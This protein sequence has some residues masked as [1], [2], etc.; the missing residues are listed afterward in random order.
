MSRVLDLCLACEPAHFFGQE[1]E[2]KEGKKRERGVGG[3]GGGERFIFPFAPKNEPARRLIYALIDRN[4]GNFLTV[5]EEGRGRVVK[6]FVGI[7]Q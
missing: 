6:V 3:G 7:D 2:N 4:F 1:R 5:V